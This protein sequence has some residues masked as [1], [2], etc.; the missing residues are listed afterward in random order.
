MSL[1]IH[2]ILLLPS[3]LLANPATAPLLLQLQHL[4]NESYT[5]TYCA[6]PTL[7]EPPYLRIADIRQLRDV[8]GDTTDGFTIVLLAEDDSAFVSPKESDVAETRRLCSAVATGS[9]KDFGPHHVKDYAK[10][11]KNLSGTEWAAGG[12]SAELGEL[13]QQLDDDD[14]L[15]DK[16]PSLPSSSSPIEAGSGLRGNEKR[17]EV[18]A[19][20]VSPAYRSLGLGARIL[21]EME[22]LLDPNSSRLQVALE[23][24]APLVR[25]L[26]VRGVDR[27]VALV[28]GIDLEAL[29]DRL[30]STAGC[31]SVHITRQGDG[32]KAR[33]KLVLMGVRELGNEGYYQRRGFKT[34]EE[35]P[36]PVGMWESKTECTA[37]YMEKVL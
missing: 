25:D 23:K 2:P 32:A 20:G 18:G 33:V 30:L 17:L 7:F 8:V 16:A 10:Y 22:W 19:F 34:V 24:D 29:R 21:S 13:W 4:L 12:R 6:D 37:V 9:I 35:R 31:Q 1:K 3:H 26:Y 15:Q 27:E 11:S 28:P 5:A 14:A 36:L